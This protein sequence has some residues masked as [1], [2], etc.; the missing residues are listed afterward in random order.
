MTDPFNAALRYHL[1]WGYGLR[2]ADNRHT[3]L[4][5]YGPERGAARL[6]RIDQLLREVDALQLNWSQQRHASGTPLA[7]LRIRIG[8]PELDDAAL[9]A[10]AWA[11]RL[12]QLDSGPAA[13]LSAAFAKAGKMPETVN[14]TALWPEAAPK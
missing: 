2:P 7:R 4:S 12:R 1:G 6:E 8:R 11:F 9:A 13:A 10:L 3:V 5:V 14:A